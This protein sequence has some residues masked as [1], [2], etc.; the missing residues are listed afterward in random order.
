MSGFCRQVSN[1]ANAYAIC[2]HMASSYNLTLADMDRGVPRVKRPEGREACLDPGEPD[3]RLDPAE[4]YANAID[5]A[6]IEEDR[7][8]AWARGGDSF[9]FDSPFQR[10]LSEKADMRIPWLFDDL[11]DDGGAEWLFGRV[12]MKVDG[13]TR[14]L[15]M[16]GSKKGTENYKRALAMEIFRF[17]RKPARRGGMGIKSGDD[18]SHENI[19]RVFSSKSAS[20]IEF[21]NLYIAIARQA[22]LE[23]RPVEVYT[24]SD[25]E[26]ISHVAVGVE[27]GRGEVLFLDA[28]GD[29]G[30]GER[31]RWSFISRQ[32]LLAYDYNS[33]GQLNCENE[34]SCQRSLYKRAMDFSPGQY[35]VMYNMGHLEFDAGDYQSSIEYFKMAVDEFPDLYEARYNLAKVHDLVGNEEEAISECAAYMRLSGDDDCRK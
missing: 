22:G 21:V 20:C 28:D 27:L 17:M 12:L 30:L 16:K 13:F 15:A 8:R 29:I 1:D 24:D 3:G 32:D 11:K 34:P 18:G 7:N 2:E 35:M 31:Q 19:H 4:V 14:S 26:G 23:A 9:T 5:L 33:R 6:E 25:G 10:F